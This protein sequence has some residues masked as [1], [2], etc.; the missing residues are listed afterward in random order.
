VLALKQ[1]GV[2]ELLQLTAVDAL[3]YN[4]ANL[5][6]REF[7]LNLPSVTVTLFNP[8]AILDKGLIESIMEI[9]SEDL[10]ELC[11]EW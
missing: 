8:K 3:Y 6:S 4:P 2:P 7:S 11:S 9:D 5:G 1:W 10:Q